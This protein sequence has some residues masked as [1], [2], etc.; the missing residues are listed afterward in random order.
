MRKLDILVPHYN[1]KYEV[2]KPL[3]DSIALQQAVDFGEI[4]VIISNDGG[5]YFD[6]ADF[7][8]DYEFCIKQICIPHKGVSAARNAAM[9]ESTAEYIM[10][11][12]IDDIFYSAC[13]LWLIF[14]EM[15]F[16]FDSLTSEFIEEAR[17]DD[18]KTIFI[19]REKDSTFVH[20]KVHRRQYLIDNNIRWNEALTVHE[21]SYFN[22]LAQ[23]FCDVKYCP[24]SFYL[25]KY[26]E[27]SVCRHDKKY[28]LKTYRNLIESNDALVDE[29]LRRGKDHDAEFHA[30]SMIFDAYYT[31]NKPTWINQ[32]NAEYRDATER[33]FAAYYRKHRSLWDNAKTENKMKVSNHVRARQVREGMVMET[34]TIEQWLSHIESL[35]T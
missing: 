2:I 26:R 30:V 21:D 29:F 18:G 12:D 16:G 15:E 8:L 22:I 10:F 6:W 13:G 19:K 34:Q 17:L 9:D 14:R 31:M 28:L 33:H 20:G 25:W 1:E 24:Y 3:L 4:G 23:S 27:S 11:C 5:Q 35:E 7:S 32:E